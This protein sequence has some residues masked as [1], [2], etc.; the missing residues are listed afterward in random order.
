M[1]K[2]IKNMLIAALTLGVTSVSG[3][4]MKVADYDKADFQ[5]LTTFRVV[6]GDLSFSGEEAPISKGTFYGWVK[7]YVR[8]DLEARGYI[9]TEDSMADFRIDYVAGSYNV[10]TNENLGPLGGTPA[11]DPSMMNQSR[12]YSESIKEGLLV[13]QIYKGRGKTLLWEAEGSVNLNPGQVERV[14]SGMIS[15]AFRKFPKAE[16][17]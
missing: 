2:L 3:Q 12:Y 17:Q 8:R 13:L 6:Q 1:K 10:N 9:F 5:Q 7:E 15:K 4:K 14:L 16:T 11:T